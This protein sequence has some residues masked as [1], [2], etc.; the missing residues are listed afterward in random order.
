MSGAGVLP[1]HTTAGVSH[2]PAVH[3][4]G[5]HTASCCVKMH[6]TPSPTSLPAPHTAVSCGVAPPTCR[7]SYTHCVQ[8]GSCPTA[9]AAPLAHVHFQSPD[10]RLLGSTHCSGCRT[11]LL[12]LVHVARH[13]GPV[14][15]P[16]LAHRRAARLPRLL[17]RAAA[18]VCHPPTCSAPHALRLRPVHHQRVV[19][20]R[21]AHHIRHVPHP[22]VCTLR[23]PV[24][25]H[26]PLL[27]CA[28]RPLRHL[29]GTPPAERLPR[30]ERRV[31]RIA[32]HCAHDLPCGPHTCGRT[33]L[34]ACMWPKPV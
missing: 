23:R 25:V 12:A 11:R 13:R 16:H 19:S 7:L 22:S 2:C 20:T 28:R 3:L 18:C 8:S 14:P 24:A 17:E 26:R 30:I 27:H 21:L 31:L 4:A 9:V 34:W 15:H 10:T 6:V 32:R 29:P 5:V 1:T 33:C